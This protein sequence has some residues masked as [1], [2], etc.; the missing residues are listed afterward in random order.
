MA[1]IVVAIVVDLDT[2]GAV[3]SVVSGVVALT[4]L[5]LSVY[6]LV[7]AGSHIGGTVS[8]GGERAAAVRGDVGRV[9]T[10][11]HNTVPPTTPAPAPP[12]A[13]PVTP[14]ATPSQSD[15][16]AS[17]NRAAAVDGNAEEII[18]GDGTHL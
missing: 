16:S 13:P 7:R 10:G 5:A 17:G 11:D 12:A 14:P 9:I 3:A 4:G 15:V 1:L 6:T 8:A 18:T 2:A